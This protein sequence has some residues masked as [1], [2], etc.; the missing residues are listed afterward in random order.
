MRGKTCCEHDEGVAKR[1]KEC[2]K[3]I[4]N[5]ESNKGNG[6]VNLGSIATDNPCER[7][8]KRNK[9]C[10]I[11]I[12]CKSRKKK[13]KAPALSETEAESNE[14]SKKK[15]ISESSTPLLERPQQERDVF[16]EK[17][18]EQEAINRNLLQRLERSQQERDTF[19]EKFL[20][21][22]EV[23]QNLTR[24]LQEFQQKTDNVARE[25]LSF[26]SSLPETLPQQFS[27]FDGRDGGLLL[28]IG[29]QQQ[30]RFQHPDFPVND[31]RNM[32]GYGQLNGPNFNYPN[33]P[34]FQ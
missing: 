1:I 22:Q 8:K 9:T 15:K 23:S 24:L 26:R 33:Y 6:S 10:V 2:I 16:G 17:L 34:R 30:N 19:R 18:L 27:V 3:K 4:R 31:P 21:Q 12:S 11:L 7:C 20:R 29:R 5:N 13:R 14:S 28:R 25:S 32:N